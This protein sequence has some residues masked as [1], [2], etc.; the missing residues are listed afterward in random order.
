[1]ATR[2]VSPTSYWFSNKMKNPANRSRTRVC[3]AKPIAIPA[4]PAVASSGA[5]GTPNSSGIITTAV[6]HTITRTTD[7]RMPVSVWAR[8]WTELATSNRDDIRCSR[9]PTMS[10]TTALI[11]AATATIATTVTR[12]SAQ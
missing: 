7:S 12:T 6:I 9:R 10:R 11:A 3:A 2:T 5:T 1:M 4:M 8:F